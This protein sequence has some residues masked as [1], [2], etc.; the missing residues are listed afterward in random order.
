[1]AKRVRTRL[2]WLCVACEPGSVKELKKSSEGIK[3]L[4]EAGEI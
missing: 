3:K 4:G 1:M 2:F